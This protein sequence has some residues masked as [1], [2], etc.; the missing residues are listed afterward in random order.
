MYCHQNHSSDLVFLLL[1]QG[2]YIE[3]NL[4]QTIRRWLELKLKFHGLKSLYANWILLSLS[5]YV[6]QPNPSQSVCGYIYANHLSF[7]EEKMMSYLSI[8]FCSCTFFLLM[9][10]FLTEGLCICNVNDQYLLIQSEVQNP[11]ICYTTKPKQK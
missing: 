10:I 5:K 8:V 6:M 7:F 4:T 11:F 2:T 1:A 3:S 9:S